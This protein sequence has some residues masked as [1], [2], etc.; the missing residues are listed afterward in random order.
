MPCNYHALQYD[1]SA[2]SFVIVLVEAASV[3]H[4]T[5]NLL[6][7]INRRKTYTRLKAEMPSSDTSIIQSLFWGMDVVDLIRLCFVFAACTVRIIP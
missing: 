5:I 2:T 4:T 6:L 1:H 3:Q 7:R